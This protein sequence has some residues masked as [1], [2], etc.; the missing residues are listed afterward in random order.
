MGLD[1]IELILAWEEAF[2]VKISDREAFALQ[3]PK[4]VVDLI[5]QK[6]GAS[7]DLVGICPTMRAYHRIRRAFQTVLGLQPQQIQLDSKLRS[8]LPKHQHQEWDRLRDLIGVPSFPPLGFGVGVVFTPITIRDL[9]N[10]A[11]A[12]HPQYFLD[13]SERWTPFQV[14][15]VVRSVVRDVLGVI[16]FRDDDAFIGR[17][18]IG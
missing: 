15:C 3:T 8:L 9:V 1:A 12:H 10:W 14:R 16:D 4:M 6:V 17:L 7:E 11:I 2:G 18:G 13:S 5:S